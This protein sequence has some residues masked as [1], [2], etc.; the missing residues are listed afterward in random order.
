MPITPPPVV[1]GSR[2]PFAINEDL[3]YS[4][5][6]G[7]LHVGSGEMRIVGMDTVRGRQTLKA[8]LSISGS[9]L[10]LHVHDTTMSWFDTSTFHSLRFVQSLHEP[11]YHAYR[12]FQIFPERE[13]LRDRDGRER[14]S[15][16]DPLDDVSFVYYVRTLPLEPGQCYEFRRYFERAG[17]P[18]VIHVERRDT[19]SVP[20][21]TFRAI[22]IRPEVTTS[23]VFSKGRAELW[24]SDDSQRLLLQMK[25]SLPFGSI[26]LYLKSVGHSAPR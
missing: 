19:V 2:L 11:H 26:N 7:K 17:N 24:L 5:S 15:V 20:A 9:V 18:V 21:G 14:P 10:F 25:S 8:V 3:Q 6:F 23:H 13:L 4:V 12:D 22:V 16:A 1:P